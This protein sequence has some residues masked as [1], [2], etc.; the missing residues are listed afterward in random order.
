MKLFILVA[1]IAAFPTLLNAADMPFSTPAP[2]QS[3]MP[4]DQKPLAMCNDGSEGKKN[5]ESCNTDSDCC[6]AMF[7]AFRKCEGPE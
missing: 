5:G 1:F 3:Q 4:S 2:A 6:G 7:C